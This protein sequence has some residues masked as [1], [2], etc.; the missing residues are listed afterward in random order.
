MLDNV[1]VKLI[2]KKKAD[3]RGTSLQREGDRL[4]YVK[5]TNTVPS[6]PNVNLTNKSLAERWRVLDARA[7]RH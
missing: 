4:G 7:E 1:F 3:V 2:K 5:L 6:E